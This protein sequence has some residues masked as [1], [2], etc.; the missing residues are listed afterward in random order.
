MHINTNNNIYKNYNINKL[1]I[2]NDLKIILKK[3]YI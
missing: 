3:Y 1:I 2:I